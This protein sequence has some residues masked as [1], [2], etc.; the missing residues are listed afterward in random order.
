[1]PNSLLEEI[2][3]PPFLKSAWSKLKRGNKESH[4]LSSETIQEFQNA[5]DANISELSKQLGKG[6][7]QFNK[8]RGVVI[9]K[10]EKG[11]FRELR[12]ADIRDRIVAKAITL[13][14]DELLT[15]KF[16]LDNKCSFAYRKNR[17][18][19]QA[20][21]AMVNFYKQGNKII[22]EADIEKFFG[23]V[24]RE[25][26]LDDIFSNLPD[27]SLNVLIVQGLSQEVGNLDELVEYKQLFEESLS[28]IPQ[29][30]ALSP[31]MA[32]ICLS[33]F[34][35]RMINEG[36]KMIRYADDFVVMCK[37]EVEALRALE[38]AKEELEEKLALKIHPLVKPTEE[39]GK[40]RIVDPVYHKFSF[41]SIRFNG[42]ELWVNEKKV[43]Q[44]KETIR[45]VTDIKYNQTVLKI[46][47][48]TKNLLE[49]WLSAFKFVDVD[50]DIK[51]I[52]D[53]I[54]F[55]LYHAL[56]KLDFLMKR[57]HTEEIKI[58]KDLRQ[59]LTVKQRKNSGIPYSKDFLFSIDR[60]RITI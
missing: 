20:I 5:L 32:N 56:R 3:H 55:Q 58:G 53:Y 42:R 44:L 38:V 7:F 30:N 12:I 46:F 31:L 21:G 36:Y 6:K 50:R 1:M 4:G 40:T 26:L 11:K 9:P 8:V 47:R 60:K 2:A 49:G 45:E 13:K 15:D 34:D 33:N 25:K 24:N 27:K 48:S 18:I 17:N 57:S 14:L 51:E 41:L 37:S 23:T 22:L 10:K 39:S 59:A 19:E 29:G 16:D 54:N 35:K 28:G 43:S 52:D